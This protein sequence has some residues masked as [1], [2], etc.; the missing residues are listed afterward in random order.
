M[1][2]A[3]GVGNN[4]RAEYATLGTMQSLVTLQLH[5][6]LAL[7]CVPKYDPLVSAAACENLAVDRPGHCTD[8][9][10]AIFSNVSFTCNCST[11]LPR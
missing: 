5:H 1:R 4:Q 7:F 6:A 2:G 9:T 3:E 8:T 11:P 10:A